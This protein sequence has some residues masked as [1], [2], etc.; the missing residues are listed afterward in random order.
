M[1]LPGEDGRWVEDQRRDL[2]DVLVRAL[3][4]LRDA[5][6]AEG[7]FGNAVRYAAEITALEPFRETSYRALMQAHVAAGN[8]A[9]ALRVYER[10]RR[11]LA[12]ELGA[13]PS[14]ESKAVYLE[15]LRS[16]PG[17]SDSEIDGLAARLAAPS[18]RRR[19][20]SRPGEIAARSRPS[21]PAPCSSGASATTAE[22]PCP[23]TRSS[24][25]SAGMPSRRLRPRRPTRHAI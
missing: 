7:E 17:S 25:R 22:R 11:F 19:T 15:I 20:T 16:S 13:Y 21:S 23:S 14:P 9:E 18:R 10:C 5:A 6:L 4:C 2:R 8:P 1:F 3:E 12:D 24:A